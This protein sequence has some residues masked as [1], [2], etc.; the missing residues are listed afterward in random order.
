ML[1][2]SRQGASRF[3]VLPCLHVTPL[4]FAAAA[5][6][7]PFCFFGLADFIAAVRCAARLGTDPRTFGRYSRLLAL[8]II[9]RCHLEL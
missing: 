7:N 8:S 1:K 6:A 5:D 9:A 4:R 2:Q 3:H